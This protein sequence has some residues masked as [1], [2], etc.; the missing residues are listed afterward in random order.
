MAKNRTRNGVYL[1]ADKSVGYGIVAQLL[2]IMNANGVSN[3][4]LVTEPEEIR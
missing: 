2:A 1:R 4:G 3:V